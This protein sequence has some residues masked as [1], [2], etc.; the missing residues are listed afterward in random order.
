[1]YKRQIFHSTQGVRRGSLLHNKRARKECENCS[2]LTPRQGPVTRP[3]VVV[4]VVISV[5]RRI[6]VIWSVICFI[7]VI[8]V[9]VV[10]LVVTVVVWV[11]IILCIP[12]VISIVPL[13]TSPV[14][15]LTFVV[16]KESCLRFALS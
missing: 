13:P 9:V 8:S 11:V 3:I 12:I 16:L 10:W 7:V 1:M 5:I 2:S 6:I 14:I 4:V 15:T